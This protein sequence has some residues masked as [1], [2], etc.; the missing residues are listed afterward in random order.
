MEQY[1]GLSLIKRALI[2][3][4]IVILIIK[5]IIQIR[6]VMTKTICLHRGTIQTPQTTQTIIQVSQTVR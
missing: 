4:T 2:I 1:A 6:L 3:K 5:Q